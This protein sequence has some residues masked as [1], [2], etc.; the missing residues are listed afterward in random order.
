M[1]ACG[2][3]DRQATHTGWP[4]PPVELKGR[5]HVHGV[6]FNTGLEEAFD[7]AGTFVF[8]VSGALLAVRKQFD[9]VGMLVLAELTALGG[10]IVRDLIL[11]EHPP[12]SF[13]DVWYL[14]VPV[15]AV[16]VTFFGHATIARIQLAV[17]VFD[18][19]GLGLFCV[20]GTAKALAFGLGPV[21]AVAL[22]ILTAVGGGML[23]D[24][25]ANEVPVVMR[26]DSVLYTVPAALGAA[27][28]AVT[29]GLQV[30]G[31]AVAGIAA[32]LAFTL[33]IVALRYN[34]R[35]PQAWRA[36]GKR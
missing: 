16:A 27:V 8:G 7:L 14:V 35:M 15:L 2:K 26:A 1:A 9:V 18:A 5:D 22:G 19:A 33:R 20:S 31:P 11:G 32:T 3:P 30:Y 13:T 25:L 12:A 10:G 29:H 24:V 34:W 4:R 23:R 36:A 21:P 28:V 6:I 17:L